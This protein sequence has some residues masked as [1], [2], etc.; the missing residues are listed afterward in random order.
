MVERK[1]SKTKQ[2]ETEIMSG[3]HTNEARVKQTSKK[4]SQKQGQQLKPLSHSLS[5]SLKLRSFSLS[6]CLSQAPFFTH[7]LFTHSLSG[8][9]LSPFNLPLFLSFFISFSILPFAVPLQD[10]VYGKGVLLV[11]YESNIYGTF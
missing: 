4:W 6:H 2:M 10:C 11:S 9:F 5:F 8:L 1:Q 3:T 7:S